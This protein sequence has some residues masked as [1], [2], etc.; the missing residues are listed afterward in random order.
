[1]TEVAVGSEIGMI[2]DKG[3]IVLSSIGGMII[4]G[5]DWDDGVL[6]KGIE[7]NDSPHPMGS[8]WINAITKTKLNA[9]NLLNGTD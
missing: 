9:K 1:V 2:S 7:A 6:E 8:I 3:V 4:V 5:T